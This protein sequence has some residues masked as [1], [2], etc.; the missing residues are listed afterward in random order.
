MSVVVPSHD[1]ARTLER[2]VASA[3]A[4]DEPPLEVIIADDASTDATA[5]IAAA[6]SAAYPE[7]V[8][9]VRLVERR[10]PASARNAGAR[11]ARA[12]LLFFLDA[13]TELEADAL[14][15]FRTTIRDA[16]AVCGVYSPTPLAPAGAGA[17][18]K[19]L[20]DHF[21]FSRA[22]VTGYD[23]F[24]AYCGG[25]RRDVFFAVGGFD[26]S[27]GPGAER[28][29]EEFGYRLSQA[30]RVLIDPAIRAR[31]H[32]AGVGRLSRNYFVRV[33]QWTGLF[34]ERG[35]FESAGDATAAGSIRTLAAPLAAG[36]W[37]LT[38]HLPDALPVA[39]ALAVVWAAGAWPF[40]RFV[41]GEQPRFVLAAIVLNVH[42]SFVISA[43]AALGALRHV[44]Q[45]LASPRRAPETPADRD[46]AGPPTPFPPAATDRV[47]AV[48]AAPPG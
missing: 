10:G 47:A 35:R 44:A 39:V 2:C 43:G 20:F 31:H 33:M 46:P 8:R 41:A 18:Y 4:S 3:L 19:A 38:P 9:C 29:N 45:R 5:R 14:T 24:S 42:F 6:L 7:H 12:P 23:G 32:F 1:A 25:V 27:L 11:A 36:A 17:R 13:D 30:H 37:L 26:E 34:L 21:S 22:G 28:E 16:D 40:V 15:H 48:R